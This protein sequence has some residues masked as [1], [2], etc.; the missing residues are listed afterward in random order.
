MV[1][2]WPAALSSPLLIDDYLE[3]HARHLYGLI[4]AHPA[5]PGAKKVAAWIRVNQVKEFKLRDV[6][7]HGWKEF[8]K[9]KDADAIAA[10]LNLLEAM[11]WV[12]MTEKSSTA[13]GGRPTVLAIVN[14]EAFRVPAVLA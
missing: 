6:R 8:A 3:P 13:K 4:E 11:G 1:H 2:W 10:A 9:E 14:P 12:R 5:L 7:R